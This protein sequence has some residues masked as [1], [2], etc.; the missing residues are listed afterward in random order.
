M[1]TT[2]GNFDFVLLLNR[3]F[4]VQTENSYFLLSNFSLCLLVLMLMSSKEL[5]E[6][7]VSVI[8]LS[9]CALLMKLIK[10]HA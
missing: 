6:H 2:A 1:G 3:H 10:H 7:D 4:A 8:F 5:S 9:R